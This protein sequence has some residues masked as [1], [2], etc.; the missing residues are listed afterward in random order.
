M[1]IALLM[2]MLLF[3]ALYIGYQR[4]VLGRA[5]A[6]LA[7]L[8]ALALLFANNLHYLNWR[9]N[10]LEI[11]QY[12]GPQDDNNGFALRTVTWTSAV[13]LIADRPLLGYG[14]RGANDALVE[15]YREKDFQRGIPE[16]Y[17]SH[18]QFLETWLESGAVG[19][20]LLLSLLGIVFIASLR[21]RSFLLSLAVVHFVLVSMVE[22]TLEIQQQ[23][24]FYLLFIF[25]FYYHYFD[26]N[27]KPA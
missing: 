13:E 6:A 21:R 26:N 11:K 9:I 3:M 8:G 24:T 1:S 5:I 10:S 23:F 17:N 2:L 27:R 12:S 15:K 16:R 22:G 14:L 18:N 7:V 19:L 25:L 20:L 4:K